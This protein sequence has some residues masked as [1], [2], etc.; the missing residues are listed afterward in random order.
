MSSKSLRCR[1]AGTDLVPVR[2]LWRGFR[3]RPVTAT[4]ITIRRYQ[5]PLFKQEGFARSTQL[6][7]VL[8]DPVHFRLK[9][10]VLIKKKRKQKKAQ[11]SV[12]HSQLKGSVCPLLLKSVIVRISANSNSSLG[13]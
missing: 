12:S 10:Q 11:Q 7:S 3:I 2:R 13:R 5:F 4:D 8:S 9:I 1:P 6:D